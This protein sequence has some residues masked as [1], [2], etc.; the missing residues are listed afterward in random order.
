MRNTVTLRH[1][2]L[3]CILAAHPGVA[4]KVTPSCF[5][6]RNAN[7]ATAFIE[8][9]DS[10]IRSRENMLEVETIALSVD[11]YMR[12]RMDGPDHPQ[13]AEYVQPFKLGEAP[14]GAGIGRVTMSY[15]ECYEEGDIVV[16]PFIGYPWSTHAVLDGEAPSLQKCPKEME[17]H[18]SHFLGAL[19]IPGLTAYFGFLHAAKI[20]PSDT[21]VVSGASGAVG[22]IATQLALKVAGAKRVL[23]IC[24][25]P[26]KCAKLEDL[27]IESHC[28]RARDFK[29]RLRRA[30]PE[31]VD[32]Y[33]DNV[34]GDI[35]ELVLSMTN[36]GARV[37]ICGQIARYNDNVS[38]ESLV[39]SAGISAEA[40]AH[41]QAGGSWRGRYLVLDY[42][43]QFEEAQAHLGKLILDGTIAAPETRY[44][45]FAPHEAFCSMMEGS[46]FGK[47]IVTLC[48]VGGDDGR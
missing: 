22:C 41:L 46:N 48:E 3:E 19:G 42:E 39:T 43:K 2:A 15:H 18:A 35:S 26:E 17:Q 37:P 14:D 13:L 11:P 34:G 28:Y 31:G 45:S 38:Y 4:R 9:M 6:V 33:F 12:C 16:A 25:S 44:H 30:L 5:E 47:A 20:T 32:V 40:S 10:K 23:G 21:V 8:A 27:G 1:R 36:N 7:A 29:D 24:G